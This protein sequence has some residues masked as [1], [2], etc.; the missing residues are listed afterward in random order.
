MARVV[1]TVAAEGSIGAEPP[2]DIDARARQFREML[3]NPGA[4]GLWVLDDQG[5]VVGLAG[6]HDSGPVGVLSVGMALLTQAR[7]QGAGRALLDTLLDHARA[8]GAHKVDLEVWPDN[9]RAIAMYTRAGFQV[10]GVRRAHYR[11]RDG[12][13]RSTLLMA[14]LLDEEPGRR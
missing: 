6:A 1:A 13:L 3:E 7:G 9:A 2:V 8:C 4:G 14:H 5:R 12:S 11:R 10:E